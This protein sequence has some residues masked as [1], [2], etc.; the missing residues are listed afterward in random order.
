MET[1]LHLW[2]FVI[3]LSVLFNEAQQNWESRYNNMIFTGMSYQ[4]K[5]LGFMAMHLFLIE[6]NLNNIINYLKFS[7]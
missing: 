5:Q 7:F 4:F 2:Q 3:V 6:I 1:A